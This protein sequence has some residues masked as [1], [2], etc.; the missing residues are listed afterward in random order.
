MDLSENENLLTLC[1][2]YSV[3]HY[4]KV[5]MGKGFSP[6]LAAVGVFDRTFNIER[7]DVTSPFLAHLSWRLMC[8]LIVYKSLRRPSVYIFKHLLL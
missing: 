4:H 1:T 3:L 6:V 8:E 7:T 5:T 2:F